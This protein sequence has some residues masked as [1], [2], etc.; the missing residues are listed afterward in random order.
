M[1]D[2]VSLDGIRTDVGAIGGTGVFSQVSPAFSAVPEG[3]KITYRLVSNPVVRQVE[4]TGNTVFKSD[5]LRSLMNI[6]PNSVLNTVL[7][8]QKIQEIENLYMKQGYIL[9]SVPDV[10]MGDDGTLHI[11][12]AE[13]TIE[14]YYSSG[15]IKNEGLCD[16]PRNEGQKGTAF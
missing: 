7:V 11:A 14:K 16:Y 5:Y 6:S 15:Q 1:G 10:K 12:I 2:T 9:V 3:V 13:G 8:N 4:F